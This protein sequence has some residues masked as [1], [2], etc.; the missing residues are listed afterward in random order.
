[1]KIGL[2]IFAILFLL[3]T[4]HVRNKITCESYGWKNNFGHFLGTFA[5]VMTEGGAWYLIF[6]A[7]LGF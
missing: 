3:W 5:L 2:C 1:M 4:T 7:F 6:K